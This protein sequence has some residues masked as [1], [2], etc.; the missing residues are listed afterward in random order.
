MKIT[1]IETIAVRIPLR[2]TYEI[3]SGSIPAGRNV[4]IRIAT[5]QGVEGLGEA[6]PIAST[7]ADTQ[8]SIVDVIAN[9]IAPRLIGQDP[10]DLPR[11]LAAVH[12]AIPGNYCAKAGI[13][14][15]LHDLAGKLLGVPV[16][17]VLG[18]RFHRQIDMLEADIWIDTP[19]KMAQT[20]RA[21]FDKGV[22]AFEIKIGTSPTL[23]VERVRAVRAAVGEQAKLRVDCNEGYA[24]GT[25]FKALRQMEAFDLEY[26][27]QPLPR[28]DFEGMARLAA[29][30]DTPICADQGAYTPHD[31]FRLLSMAAADL[32]CIK[33]PKSGLSGALAIHAICEAAGVKCTLGSML[34]LGIG[35]AAI[36]HFGIHARNVD[37]HS[38]G[39]YGN[40]LEYF[41]DDVVTACTM[42]ADGVLRL[43]DSPGLGVALDEAKLKQY[44]IQ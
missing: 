29:A 1:G 21:A 39:I 24:A 41:M 25:A 10:R 32:I 42:D 11:L 38:S 36:H 26:I 44:A 22:R 27:E 15:G 19:E 20:A 18:G 28:W 17:Q 30:L 35:A 43:S 4:I 37:M 40:P 3:A 9:Q 6:S 34:P 8:R 5:D 12:A 31:V 7:D 14:I 23:D 33:I 2:R 13:D 16:Y